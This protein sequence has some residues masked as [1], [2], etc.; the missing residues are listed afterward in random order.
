M[1]ESDLF[2]VE[3]TYNTAQELAHRWVRAWPKGNGYTMA[4][5]VEL[6]FFFKL[7][8]FTAQPISSGVG[9]PTCFDFKYLLDDSNLEKDAAQ[10]YIDAE[11]KRLAPY[12][13]MQ[14]LENSPEVRRYKEL[15]RI[16]QQTFNHGGYVSAPFVF[17]GEKIIPLGSMTYFT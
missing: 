2:L 1:T 6:N 10:W 14:E 9:Y 13:E 4:G 3:K 15:E 11:E 12:K 17:A 16:K 7:V 5:K 8:R